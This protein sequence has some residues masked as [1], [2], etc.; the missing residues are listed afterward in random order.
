MLQGEKKKN[1]QGYIFIRLIEMIFTPT[2]AQL[3]DA[4]RQIWATAGQ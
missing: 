3:S 1:P 4:L 2:D